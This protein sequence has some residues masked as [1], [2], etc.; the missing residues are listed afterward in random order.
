MTSALLGSKDVTRFAAKVASHFKTNEVIA[1]LGVAYDAHYGNAAGMSP[2]HL[3]HAFHNRGCLSFEQ[4]RELVRWKLGSL[5]VPKF[6]ARNSRQSVKRATQKLVSVIGT[7]SPE[8]ALTALTNNLVQVGPAA[9]SA[10][11]AAWSVDF[12]IIDTRAWNS[13]WRATGDQYFAPNSKLSQV[14]RPGNY[15]S[16]VHIVRQAAQKLG[17]SVREL[18]S[19]LYMTG[20]L[21]A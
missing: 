1:W 15:D 19:A 2:E 16:Y 21:N 17:V 8:T 11:L 4:A 12:P 9:G 20:K 6:V 10:F 13:L 7:A 3:R 18:E 14:F 5:R